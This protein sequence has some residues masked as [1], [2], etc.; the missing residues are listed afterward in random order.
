M[1]KIKLTEKEVEYLNDFVKMGR[2]AEALISAYSRSFGMQAWIF[3][4]TKR[5]IGEKE[6]TRH[7]LRFHTKL[8]ER[9]G[10]NLKY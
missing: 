3:R 8:K 5:I 4:F 7:H 1:E 2:A 10:M 6:Y 9:T